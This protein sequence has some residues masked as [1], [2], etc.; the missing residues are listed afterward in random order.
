MGERPVAITAVGIVCGLGN[1]AQQVQ[2]GLEQ[3][4]SAVGPTSAWPAGALPTDLV[5]EVAG[6]F[7]E[8]NGF[9][10]D[11][12]VAL[13]AA[14]LRQLEVDPA[15]PSARRG[16]FLGTGL[17]SVTPRELAE[18]VYPHIVAG[19][20]DR[21]RATADVGAGRAAPDRHHPSRATAWLAQT[22]GATGP[23]RTSF[24]ACAAAAEAIAAGARAIARGDADVVIAGGHDSMNHPLG[25]L[26]FQA[27]GALSPGAARPFDVDR[28]GFVLGEGAAL[29]RLEPLDRAEAP[30][31]VIL[32][33]GSSMDA[34]GVTAP[35][36]DGAGAEAAMRRALREGGLPASEVDW[37]NAH[38]T[39]TPVGDRAEAAA[40]ERLFGASV[41]VSSLKGALGHG[42]AAAGALEIVATVLAWSG[43]FTPG[44]TGCQ[45][46]DPAMHIDVIQAPR[47]SAPGVVLSN[48]F[49]FGGQNTSLL[50]APECL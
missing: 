19:R 45:R 38:A 6:E 21:E 13:L 46:A 31:G 15:V 37:I 49:G 10:D 30:L 22:I 26:S 12:K 47:P 44:T 17:S 27:L 43:G 48:S 5:V 34:H 28:D 24:S 11:R 9:A 14:A 8:P 35:H 3:G 41:G 2:A 42:L 29:V 25:M 33:A 23:G 4:R 32:G 50:L 20:V 40:I 16:V 18:D 39:G 7:I 36:P 1:D